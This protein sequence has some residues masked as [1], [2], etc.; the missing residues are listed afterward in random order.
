ML[1]GAEFLE[2]V[3]EAGKGKMRMLGQNALA[4]GVEFF[5]DGADPLFLEIVGGGEREGVEALRLG[6]AWSIF[7]CSALRQHPDYM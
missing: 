7:Q 6:V 4:V 2:D 1:A 5:R 3:V